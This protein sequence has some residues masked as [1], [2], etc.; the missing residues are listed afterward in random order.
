LTTD[1][2]CIWADRESHQTNGNYRSFVYTKDSIPFARQYALSLTPGVIPAV[3]P[4]I[5]ALIGSGVARYGGYKLLDK[6]GIL[7]SASGQLKV[8]PGNKDAVFKS[9]ELS[10]IDKRRLMRFLMFAAGEYE[11]KPELEGKEQMPFIEFLGSAFSL[12]V[13]IAEAVTYAIAFCQSPSGA[14]FLALC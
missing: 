2:F 14:P 10:L 12:P 8:V 3:G 13:S 1:E 7:D 9:K 5:T 4:L 6:I 11:G